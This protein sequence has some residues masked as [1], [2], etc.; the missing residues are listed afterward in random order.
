MSERPRSGSL[1]TG[2]HPQ[3]RR[4][5]RNCPPSSLSQH[6]PQEP[7][8]PSLATF[9]RSCSI[10]QTCARR[11]RFSRWSES[12]WIVSVSRL[13]H[14]NEWVPLCCIHQAAIGTLP[15]AASAATMEQKKQKTFAGISGSA[16]WPGSTPHVFRGSRSS[17]SPCQNS[18]ARIIEETG[19]NREHATRHELRSKTPPELQL[20]TSMPDSSSTES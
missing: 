20:Q 11:S 6:I 15:R 19:Q 1:V 12:W 13:F 8:S 3:R 9:C 4:S 5:F 16:S 18:G 17:G 10:P 14:G 2:V 7:D